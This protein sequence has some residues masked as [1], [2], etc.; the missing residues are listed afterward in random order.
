MSTTVRAP[1]GRDEELGAIARLLDDPELR[2]S[3]S[4]AGRE[5]AEQFS[6]PRVTAKVDD[7][8]GFVIR[9]LAATG[10]LPEDFRSPVPQAPPLRARPSASP[11]D[12]SSASLSASVSLHAHAE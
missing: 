3:M 4:A 12:P 5:R 8:Y 6:W 9:R 11:D 7:Y 10:Q 1:I 2:A